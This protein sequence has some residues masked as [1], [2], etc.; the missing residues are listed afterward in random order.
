MLH[1]IRSYTL[2]PGKVPEY[3]KLAEEVSLP[4]RK[5]DAGI[6]IGWFSSEIGELN[7]LVHIWEWKD[8]EERQ[9]QRVVLRARPGWL[10][11]Y[12]PQVDKLVYRREV[13]IINPVLPVRPPAQPGNVYELRV[14]RTHP[15][16]LA[17]WLELFKSVLPVREK[18]SK[19]VGLWQSE[20]GELNEVTH[21]W[22]YKDLKERAEVRARASRDPEWQAFLPKSAPLLFHMSSTILVPA[23]FSPLQ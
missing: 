12:N 5:N 21:L 20:I 1:E 22:A 14:Y 18:Y 4:I 13:S 8:L 6:L 23:K 9:R 17:A 15:G 7:K 10:D 19:I 11:V 3:L 2:V 16:K